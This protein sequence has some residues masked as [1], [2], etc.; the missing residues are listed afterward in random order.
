[1]KSRISKTK[2]KRI[3]NKTRFKTILLTEIG[4]DIGYYWWILVFIGNYWFLLVLDNVDNRGRRRAYDFKI[5]SCGIFGVNQK[6]SRGRKGP[7]RLYTVSS[8]LKLP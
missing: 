8:P 4:K 3:K 6:H 7:R 5:R 1:V 2:N